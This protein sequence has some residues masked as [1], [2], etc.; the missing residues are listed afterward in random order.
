MRNVTGVNGLGW[1]GFDPNRS[2]PT[3]SMY[4]PQ[5]VEKLFF[6]YVFIN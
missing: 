1:V 5:K 3:R 4:T 6:H 2:D